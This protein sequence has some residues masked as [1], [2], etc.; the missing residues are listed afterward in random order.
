MTTQN[1]WATPLK[2]EKESLQTPIKLPPA[3]VV[4]MKKQKEV[5][6]DFYSDDEDYDLEDEIED[7]ED[8]IEYDLDDDPN[9]WSDE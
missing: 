6:N 7:D 5:K 8:D 9:W 1:A 3:G 2:V 4:K